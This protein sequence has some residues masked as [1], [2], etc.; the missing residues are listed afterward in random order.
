MLEDVKP[1][2][3]SRTYTYQQHRAYS[4]GYYIHCSTDA[5]LCRYRAYRHET[6]C[7]K[8]FV[9]E[10]R[11]FAN[12]AYSWLRNAKP[13]TSLTKQQWHG[14]NNAIVCH[15]CGQPFVE[16]DKKVRDHCHSTGEYRG[17]THVSCNLQFQRSYTIPVVFHN[18]S[19]YD[20]HFIIKELASAFEGQIDLLPVTKGRYISFTKHVKGIDAENNDWKRGLKFRFIDSLKFLAASLEKLASDLG[21]DRLAILRRVFQSLSYDQ[22]NLLTREGCLPVRLCIVIRQTQ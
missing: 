1:A 12:I 19:G 17:A 20:A 7:V 6:E 15:V 9:Q 13:M 4:V 5:S 3:W 14:F 22:F 11:D 21:K 18:L 10:L 8:W 16:E 2:E